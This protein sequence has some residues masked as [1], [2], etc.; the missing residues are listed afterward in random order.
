MLTFFPQ[1]ILDFTLISKVHRR[2]VDR[3]KGKWLFT[4][5]SSKNE[6]GPFLLSYGF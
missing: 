4:K 6:A 1:I 3:L 2:D 5:E